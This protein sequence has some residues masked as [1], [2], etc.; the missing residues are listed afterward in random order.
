ME[1][2]VGTTGVE[3][4]AVFEDIGEKEHG[5]SIDGNSRCIMHDKKPKRRQKQKKRSPDGNNEDEYSAAARG[6][7][8][9][10]SADDCLAEHVHRIENDD[11]FLAAAPAAP[12]WTP[13]GSRGMLSGYLSSTHQFPP[14]GVSAVGSSW[15]LTDSGSLDP[16][17]L[18]IESLSGLKIT[19]TIGFSKA[20]KKRL[21]QQE[22]KKEKEAA[23]SR[24]EEA[25]SKEADH[26]RWLAET[27]DEVR[28]IR[29][30]DGDSSDELKPSVSKV[31]P[32][33]REAHDWE[34]EP[35]G[36]DY[37]CLS[38][39]RDIIDQFDE[40]FILCWNFEYIQK[41]RNLETAAMI[42]CEPT[43][44]D[45]KASCS[46]SLSLIAGACDDMYRL[47]EYSKTGTSIPGASLQGCKKRTKWLADTLRAETAAA[48]SIAEARTIPTEMMDAL[49][50]NILSSRKLMPWKDGFTRVFEDVIDKLD[51]AYSSQLNLESLADAPGAVEND[52]WQW[53]TGDF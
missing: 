10:T 27:L 37:E 14:Q 30:G 28:K 43:T 41:L 12:L 29:V 42:K 46:D 18:G 38:W 1:R 23:E 47:N 13:T 15:T 53:S 31:V 26:K 33:G 19:S 35:D 52:L 22:A 17:D 51:N 2:Q 3:K 39:R 6:A 50:L 44:I 24:K 16:R 11:S 8:P 32:S 4:Q 21:R 48:V 45:P 40:N 36:P 49:L 25:K 34:V 7:C 9:A 5:V 20:Q